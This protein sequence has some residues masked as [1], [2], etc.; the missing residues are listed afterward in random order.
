E[1][2]AGPVARAPDGHTI[3]STARAGVGGSEMLYTRRLDQPMSRVIPGTDGGA[4]PVFAADGRSIYYIARRR[5]LAKVA[6]DGATPVMLADVSDNGGLDVSTTGDIVLGPGASEG[7][8]GLFR[9]NPGGGP[10]VPFT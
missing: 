10:L 2:S 5:E 4:A 3:V 9:V 6:L 1:V 7:G 8:D